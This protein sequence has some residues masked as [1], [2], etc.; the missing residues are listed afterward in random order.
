MLLKKQMLALC[1]REMTEQE[2]KEVEKYRL[3]LNAEE[4]LV[5]IGKLQAV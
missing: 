4:D 2:L 5:S 3:D 1:G